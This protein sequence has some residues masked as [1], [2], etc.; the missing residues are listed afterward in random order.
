MPY[1]RWFFSSKDKNNERN[2]L[3]SY[4]QRFI[5]DIFTR[6]FPQMTDKNTSN[7]NLRQDK[8]E[9][10][11][12]EKDIRNSNITTAT[13]IT[14]DSSITNEK[15]ALIQ[16][17]EGESNKEANISS[18]LGNLSA[19][20]YDFCDQQRRPS[21][22]S[23]EIIRP[24]EHVVNLTNDTV[25]IST[26][27]PNNCTSQYRNPYFSS[28][29]TTP[30]PQQP[31]GFF[32]KIKP[33]KETLTVIVLPLVISLIG[34]T[35]AIVVLLFVF[36]QEVKNFRES[37]DY[38]CMERINA[39]ATT[40]NS[41]LNIGKDF[42]GFFTVFASSYPNIMDD[43]YGIV[44][45][46]GNLSA[47]NNMNIY[48]I[49]FAPRI[50][51]SDRSNFE[52]K[53]GLIKQFNSQ[54]QIVIRG[55]S[56][57]Y[58]PVVY[59]IPWRDNTSVILNYD[60]ASESARS[61]AIEKARQ[62][63]NITITQRIPLA[64]NLSI[65][66]ISVYFPFYMSNNVNGDVDGLVIGIYE[67]DKTIQSATQNFSDKS[68][69]GFDIVDTESNTSIYSK[70]PK[71]IWHPSNFN[72]QENYQIADRN[73]QFTCYSSKDSYNR[74]VSI[75]EPI[76]YFILILSFFAFIAFFTSNYFRKLF[77]ARYKFT[78]QAVKLGRTQSLLKAITADSKA[79]LEAIADPLFALNAKG[80]IVGANK[81]A[82]TLTGYSPEEIK[83]AN[84]M[85][86][87][88]L[89]IPV[90]ET[91]IEERNNNPLNGDYQL[92][93]VPVRP[94]MRDVLAKK[95]DGTLFEAEAN[96]SQ[97]IVEKNYFTQVV[98]FRDVSF[99]KE[100]ERAVMDAKR[101]AD[102]ANQSK[103]EFLFFLCHEIRN[104]IHAILG[105][106]EMLQNSLKEKE[107]FEELDYIIS[108]GK[109]LSF[110]VNDVLDLTHLTNPNPYEIELKCD[111]FN[112]YT[113]VDNISKIQSIEAAHKQIQVKTIISGGLQKILYGD[114]CRL[115]QILMKLLARSIEVAP[116]NGIVE[117]IVE[118]KI[119]HH[120]KGVLLRFSVKDQSKGLSSDEEIN[121]L[122][123]PYAKTN[124]SIG[125][126]FHAQGLSMALVQAIVKVMGG[127]LV[128]EKVDRSS[129]G[130]KRK[131]NSGNNNNHVWFE[132]WLL[133]EE[134]KDRGRLLRESYDSLAISKNGSAGRNSYKISSAPGS[135]DGKLM[136]DII[137]HSDN[138]DVISQSHLRNRKS[139]PAKPK[140]DSRY[141]STIRKKRRSTLTTAA[142]TSVAMNNGGEDSNEEETGSIKNVP[143][144][145]KSAAANFF[146]KGSMMLA[147]GLARASSTVEKPS[148]S[149]LSTS[150][151]QITAN[152]DSIHR[153]PDKNI[154]ITSSI[155]MES[156]ESAP[157]PPIISYYYGGNTSVSPIPPVP[158]V[159]PLTQDHN[160][161]LKSNTMKS[162][163][164]KS[165]N[166]S[167]VSLT[168][169]TSA[170]NANTSQNV[171]ASPH[172]TPASVVSTSP[173]LLNQ[174]SLHIT[175][176]N[177]NLLL[178]PPLS[179]YDAHPPSLTLTTDVND[180]N[181]ITNNSN[182]DNNKKPPTL[183]NLADKQ[184]NAANAAV[185][186]APKKLKILLVEDNLVCQRVTYKM[187]N[188]NNYLV[189]IANHGKE[190]V[191]MVEALQQQQH[192]Q[193]YACILMD[194]ITPVMNGY[195]A[196]QILRDR[197]VKIPILALTA[198]SFESDVKRAKDVGMDDFLTKP[199]K[200]AELIIAIKTQ[201]EK[202][203]SGDSSQSQQDDSM[204]I[205]VEY[206]DQHLTVNS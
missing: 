71:I 115:K 141:M 48:S 16:V 50:P 97:P 142:A 24:T 117:L 151:S 22:L 161:K 130:S 75:Y 60:V 37:F 66:G 15:N 204:E 72:K 30:I 167:N 96:F 114:E 196:T 86:I 185:T 42:V 12:K 203:E 183:D 18:G 32:T 178:T 3:R 8:E 41:G 179:S 175:L 58:F 62:T 150:F 158:S 70:D 152:E 133:T 7:G 119:F 23:S 101:D 144:Q 40:F 146:R 10:E 92:I 121:E 31:K 67:L 176:P 189:D 200:E 147:S 68:G 195:E 44:N 202:F 129:S 145:S 52:A 47:I 122:F 53:H 206:K 132:I 184:I 180:T 124:S 149:P 49:N 36:D 80:E 199:I 6:L 25:D 120:I 172:D 55:D 135:T 188:R 103:T 163:S 88:T 139:M 168:I 187:L 126:R 205:P 156:Q 160:L 43:A 14:A 105:F 110:I 46:Y 1:L 174:H 109:F 61:A 171:L 113:L 79:V 102:L 9:K 136:D 93:E 173:S 201:I 137:I 33:S 166:S 19:T 164:I 190:S 193:Q 116:S 56:P 2:R 89:L 29:S 13:T 35:I 134:T 170:T 186:E 100:T 140:R 99:K 78:E 82:L 197:G 104:P 157:P 127:R 84:K 148:S 123:K 5:S 182:N 51:F 111:G 45:T 90:A 73:W 191:D 177:N 87:N 57:E 143:E 4:R 74:A 106:A 198:N 76:I 81:H 27:P 38:I 131:S 153:G 138:E 26:I 17:V 39:V 118:Q 98:M 194:I 20:A 83:V 107:Q 34:L 95:K 91:P 21:D 65:G 159:P 181:S 155:Q 112:I 165:R 154:N 108:A 94:G 63:R 128:V 85:H 69:V 54:K 77:K 125:S 169:S 162:D 64:Y 192:Q 59:S 28:G 11:E